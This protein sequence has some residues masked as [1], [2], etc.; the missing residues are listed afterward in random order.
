MHRNSV[1]SYIQV[2]NATMFHS[3]DILNENTDSQGVMAELV[4]HETAAR[5]LDSSLGQSILSLVK[6]N[7]LA[8]AVKGL[9]E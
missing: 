7:E 5:K 1:N 4:E 9:E 3:L 2:R 8:R 6:I